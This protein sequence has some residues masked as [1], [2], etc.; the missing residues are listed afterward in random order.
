MIAKEPHSVGKLLS[1]LNKRKLLF[2]MSVMGFIRDSVVSG[3]MFKPVCLCT[4]GHSDHRGGKKV[5]SNKQA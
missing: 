3:L 1:D 2:Q 4:E 5:V